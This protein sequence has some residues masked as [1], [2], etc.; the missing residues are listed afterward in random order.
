MAIRKRNKK[1][2]H[3]N[4]SVKPREESIPSR[5]FA[6]KNKTWKEEAIEVL[7]LLDNQGIDIYS[8]ENYGGMYLKQ[9]GNQT[10]HST[11]KAIFSSKTNSI[12]KKVENKPTEKKLTGLADFFK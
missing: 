1:I 2:I 3:D 8:S 6:V 7:N 9:P 12:N 11:V 5:G 4:N 10:S